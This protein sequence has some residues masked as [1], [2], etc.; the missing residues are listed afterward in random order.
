MSL[1]TTTTEHATAEEVLADLENEL[2]RLQSAVSHLTLSETAATKAI[3]A[4]EQVLQ[5]Q[6]VLGQQL[7]DYVAKMPQPGQGTET[8]AQ[9]Q[10]LNSSIERQSQQLEDVQ[11]QLHKEQ[12]TQMPSGMPGHEQLLAL[13]TELGERQ[14]SMSQKVELVAQAVQK[15]IAHYPSQQLNELLKEVIEPFLPVVEMQPVLA[16]N[17]QQLQEMQLLLK[18]LSATSDYQGLR[19]S[20][21]VLTN[22]LKPELGQVAKQTSEVQQMLEAI[23]SQ[24]DK[25]TLAEQRVESLE[26]MVR[27][28]T[29]SAMAQQ[30][31][32]KW[33][34][35]LTLMTLVTVLATLA[36]LAAH[37][38]R[39]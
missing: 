19:E 6:R 10:M 20:I 14:S 5:H 21:Q 1:D 30:E 3:E 22:S 7:T 27:S 8:L 33:Q 2:K 25:P 4:A 11:H 39:G 29:R 17:E 23:K 28:L 36:G 24:L 16:R 12:A 32:Q 15:G 38:L 18:N 13:T 35:T 26:Q 31:A 37:F 9:L 34:N